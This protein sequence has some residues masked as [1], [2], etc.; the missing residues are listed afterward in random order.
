MASRAAAIS[1]SIRASLAC[2]SSL[3][4]VESAPE[5]APASGV[6]GVVA[7]DGNAWLSAVVGTSPAEACDV[8][9]LVVMVAR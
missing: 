1:V 7:D 2:S 9:F 5:F 4:L 8:A 6:I 3:E